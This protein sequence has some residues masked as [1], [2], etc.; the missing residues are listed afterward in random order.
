LISLAMA[1]GAS[2]MGQVETV[3]SVYETRPMRFI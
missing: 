1:V 2:A 3:K